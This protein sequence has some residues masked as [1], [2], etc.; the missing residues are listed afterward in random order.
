[1]ISLGKQ[2]LKVCE[3]N[4]NHLSEICHDLNL[5][6]YNSD[7]RIQS[8]RVAQNLIKLGCK[9]GDV[10]TLLLQNTPVLSPIFYGCIL[11]GAPVNPLGRTMDTKEIARKIDLVKPKMIIFDKKFSGCVESVLKMISYECILIGNEK[12]VKDLFQETGNENDFIPSDFDTTKTVLGYLCSSGTTGIS[13]LIS[14][15]HHNLLNAIYKPYDFQQDISLNFSLLDWYSGFYFYL[16]SILYQRTRISTTQQFSADFALEL[17]E[18]YKVTLFQCDPYSLIQILQSP[19]LKNSDLSNL[20]E[21]PV[22]GSSLAYEF[23]EAM[24]KYLP[25]CKIG[26]IYGLTEISFVSG[27]PKYVT[28]IGS[29]GFLAERIQ[30]KIYDEEGKLLGPNQVGELHM[31]K[32][33]EFLG[34]FK[35]EA[36]TRDTF[37][38]DGWLIS[39]DLG[40]IDDDGLLFIVGRNKEM[41]RFC[42]ENVTN[43]FSGNN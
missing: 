27:V 7:I 25:N 33:S 3:K 2:I 6:I 36:A 10:I 13:K 37:D 18:K 9:E 39:G 29:C 31:V 21:F 8:I 22:V 16:N 14:L 4:P 24:D 32:G 42:N 26:N 5:K 35:D 41:L 11:I 30:L 19:K 1:M 43:L 28:K 23:K 17:L 12:S 34:Y 38:Q 20:K 15:S 40:Y